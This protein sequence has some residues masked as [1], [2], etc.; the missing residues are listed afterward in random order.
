MMLLRVI[1]SPQEIRRVT[2]QDV[3]SSVDELCIVLRNTLGLWGNFILQFEDPDF[4]NALQKCIA[5]FELQTGDV[6]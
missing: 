3:P 2:L 6:S 4:W 1:V 5:F